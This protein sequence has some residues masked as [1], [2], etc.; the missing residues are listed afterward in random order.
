M[1]TVIGTNCTSCGI[2]TTAGGWGLRVSYLS[3]DP[4]D[5]LGGGVYASFSLLVG[6]ALFCLGLAAS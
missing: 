6:V 5:E 2:I 4:E 1:L 3:L